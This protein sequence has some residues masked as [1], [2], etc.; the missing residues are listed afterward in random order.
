MLRYIPGRALIDMPKLR[1]SMFIDRADQFKTRLGWN[2]SVDARGFEQDEYDHGDTLYVI[3][4]LEDGTHGGS[5][6]FLPTTGRTMA[7]DH[8]GHLANGGMIRDQ[9]VWECTRFCLSRRASPDVSVKLML[10]GAEVG[11]YFDLRKALGV[12]DARMIRIYRQLDWCP[13]V[14]GSSGSGRS[15]VKLGLWTFSEKTRLRL[16]ARAGVQP[17]RSKDWLMQSL[18]PMK[19]AA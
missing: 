16:A 15:S 7:N 3:W 18:E 19:A 2:V 8:F 5:M 17:E 14:V 12:F 10:G 13:V 4:E 11:A 9:S 1:Q 6:R